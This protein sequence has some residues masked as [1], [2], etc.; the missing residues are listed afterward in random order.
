MIPS[1]DNLLL[2]A[3]ASV[4]LV[5][6][7]GPNL[8]YLVSRTLCQGRAAGVISLAGT[9][10]GFWF[11]IMAAAFGLSA[12]FATVP[13][14]YEM[15]RYTGALYLLWLAVDALR[16]GGRGLF[17]LRPMPALARGRLF[18]MGVLTSVLNP[19]VA[20]FYLALFPQ[21]VDPTRGSVLVQSLVLGMVQ[22]GI[23]IVGDMIF[24][25]TAARVAQWLQHRPR[26][27][28]AQRWVLAGTFAAIAARLALVSER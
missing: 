19:K 15:V 8:L 3:G 21:F 20:L 9:T 13:I 6:T 7:P 10:T 1:L 25:L 24:I 12:V 16:A 17:A 26:W 27:A 28:A 14:A 5:L 18:R 11:H 4:L 23:A 2:F 22:I